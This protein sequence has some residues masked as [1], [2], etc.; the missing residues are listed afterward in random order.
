MR[1]VDLI[2]KKREG[3]ELSTE[4]IEYIISGY[5][6]NTIPDYQVSSF[7]MAVFFRGMNERETADLTM[8][9]VKSGD[10]IDLSEIDGIKVDKHSTGGVGDTTTL[11]LGPLVASAGVPVAK[12]S[13]RGLGH[14]GGTIDK[15]ESIDGF[16]VELNNQEFINQVNRVKLAVIGQSANLTPADKKLYSLRDVTATIESTPMIAG[17]IMSKKIAAGAEAI[18]LD[19]K[20]GDGAFMKTTEKSF[21]LAEALVNIGTS[22]NRRTVAVVSDMDQPLGF[23]VGNAIEVKEAIDTLNGNGPR[24]LEELCLFLGAQML[25]LADKVKTIDEGQNVLR[26]IIDSGKAIKTMKE[27]VSAQGGNPDFIDNPDLLPQAEKRI[28]VV[29]E[30][31]GYIHKIKAEE[32]G[33]SAMLLGAGRETKQSI[34]DLAVGIVLDKKVGEYVQCGE[35][36]ATLHVN[37]QINVEDVKNRVLNAYRIEDEKAEKRKLIYGVVSQKGIEKY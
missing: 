20:T 26:E 8:S 27:F 25:L 9:M 11:V 5:T 28:E 19:V 33:L 15:L 35:T 10:Q 14:T 24:D 1:M 30:K 16:H 6:N 2:H 12:M 7:A 29:A 17:S 18:V 23:A 37:N 4:E 21:E 3:L 22:T 13:G 31:A 32:I 34:I 36:L